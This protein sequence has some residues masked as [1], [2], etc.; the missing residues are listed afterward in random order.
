MKIKIVKKSNNKL[1]EYSTEL[2]AGVDL[3]ANIVKKINLKPLE[4]MLVPT[5]LFVELPEGYEPKFDQE[6]DWK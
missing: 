5:G 6:A 2:S 1:P 4:R 3:R